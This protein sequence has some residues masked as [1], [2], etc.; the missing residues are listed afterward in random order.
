MTF[1]ELL[2]KACTAAR[3]PDMARIQLPSALSDKTKR[4]LLKLSPEEVGRVLSRAIDAVNHGSVK[5]I[6]TLVNE[7]L[8]SR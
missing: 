3:L 1:E 4:K 6:D 8:N 5:S 7:Q 2:D